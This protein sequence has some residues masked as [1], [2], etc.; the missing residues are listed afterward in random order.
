MGYE[1]KVFVV[2]KIDCVTY[3]SS[4]LIALI[5][6]SKMGYNNGWRELFKKD[7][8][9]DLQYNNEIIK[10]DCYGEIPKYTTVSEVLNWLENDTEEYYMEDVLKGVLKPLEKQEDILVVHYG[11]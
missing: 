5:D 1:S 11:Y 3:K 8:D 7:I 6:M 4:L 2:R 10:E 9:F